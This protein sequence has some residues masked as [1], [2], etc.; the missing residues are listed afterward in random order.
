M[1][2]LDATAVVICINILVSEP[3]ALYLTKIAFI[4]FWRDLPCSGLPPSQ[5]SQSVKGGEGFPRRKVYEKQLYEKQ[6]Y[7][8]TRN[9]WVSPTKLYEKQSL[10][11][12]RNICEI[13]TSSIASQL[14]TTKLKGIFATSPHKR[15]EIKG[16]SR[17]NLGLFRDPS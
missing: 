12:L 6:L 2:E 10:G 5:L 14:L 17:Q 4:F 3:N 1:N 15:F 7:N 13:K 16:R 9:N 11:K 8:C